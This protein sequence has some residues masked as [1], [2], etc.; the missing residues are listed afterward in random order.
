MCCSSL[1][2]G[3]QLS[4]HGPSISEMVDVQRSRSDLIDQC[5]IITRQVHLLNGIIFDKFFTNILPK[6]ST[7]EKN[8]SFLEFR[9]LFSLS[10]LKLNFCGKCFARLLLTVSAATFLM[11]SRSLTI[12]MFA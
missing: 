2:L 9:T 11:G 3:S 10:Y 1:G 12:K 4:H 5:S 7:V 6:K 8:K